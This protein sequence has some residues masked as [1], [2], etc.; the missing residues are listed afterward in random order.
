MHLSALGYENTDR[1]CVAAVPGTT[2][3]WSAP[4]VLVLLA[5]TALQDAFAYAHR[6]IFGVEVS[7][8]AAN[9][10]GCT[11]AMVSE[12]TLGTLGIS[13]ADADAAWPRVSEAMVEYFSTLDD[14]AIRLGLE[15]LPGVAELL[16]A[17]SAAEDCVVGLVTGNLEPIAWAKM[18]GLGIAHFFSVPRVG[19][20]GSDHADRDVLVTTALQRAQQLYPGVELK[21]SHIG[22]TPKDVTAARA[23]GAQAVGVCTGVFSASDLTSADPEAIVL[24]NLCDTAVVLKH[25]LV[26]A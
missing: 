19:G 21:H 3:V 10:H 23:G 7:I 5:E 14:D 22:D 15:L 2:S 12:R 1:T 9:H 6:K 8:D 17:L 16:A 20:F 24:E 25:L 26:A 18:R 4:C 11:D 13:A